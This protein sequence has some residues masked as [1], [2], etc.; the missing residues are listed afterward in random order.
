MKRLGFTIIELLVVIA[1][2]ASLMAITVPVLSKS[3][4]EA[5]TI[6]CASNIRQIFFALSA[7]EY[8][9]HRLAYSLNSDISLLSNPPQ[10]GWAGSMDYDRLGWWWFNY[11]GDYSKTEDRTYLSCPSKN[12]RDSRLKNNILCG[13]YGVNTSILRSAPPRISRAEFTGTPL[14]LADIRRPAD[15]LIIVDCGY[16]M[17]NWGYV[18]DEPPFNFGTMIEDTAYIPGMK[19]NIEKTNLMDCQIDD[20]VSGRHPNKTVNAGFADGHVKRQKAEEL[21]VEKT[22]AGYKNRTPWR[23]R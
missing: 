1:I 8:D 20:A 4:R 23:P 7:Y 18:T 21:F 10:G 11:I 22:P 13:N 5:K 2:I 19:I 3:R 16:S 17:I 6:L 15:I 9:N 12:I 14:S